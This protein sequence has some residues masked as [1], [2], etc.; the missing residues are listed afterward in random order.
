MGALRLLGGGG[1]VGDVGREHGDEEEEEEGVRGE[2]DGRLGEVFQR[3]GR[4]DGGFF[5]LSLCLC[6]SPKSKATELDL[7]RLGL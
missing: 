5:P 2:V 3:R 4:L 6:V 1:E 7:V